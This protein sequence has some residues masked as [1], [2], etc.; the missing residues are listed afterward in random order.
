MKDSEYGFTNNPALMS[1]GALLIS[2]IR[3]LRS[4]NYSGIG[5]HM[6]E[7]PLTEA[8]RWNMPFTDPEFV[9]E[10]RSEEFH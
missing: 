3:G 9:Y 7:S 1:K 4:G 2:T 6:L 10:Q 8:E 5:Y